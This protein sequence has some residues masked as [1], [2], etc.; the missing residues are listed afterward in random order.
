MQEKSSHESRTYGWVS[1]TPFTCDYLAPTILQI[2]KTSSAQRILDIGSGNGALANMLHSEGFYVSGVEYDIEGVKISQKLFPQINFYQA[3]VEDDPDK[4]LEAEREAF[5]CVVSTEVIEHLY[6]PHLLLSFAKSLLKPGGTLILSTPY[7]GYLKNLA[8]SIFGKWD[9]HHNPLWYGGHIKFF[10]RATLTQL[11]TEG[12]YEVIDFI[13]AGR[14]PY[15]WKSMILVAK[16]K[17]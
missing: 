11:L 2:L 14:L 9:H 4:I 5:D 3:G 1:T 12:G 13:G 15:L 16:L 6:S 7:H 10:S 8:V 17:N